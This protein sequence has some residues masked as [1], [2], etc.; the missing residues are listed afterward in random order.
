MVG[1]GP[2]SETSC[3]WGPAGPLLLEALDLEDGGTGPVAAAADH[4]AVVP[5]PAVRDGTA[6][7]AGVDVAGDGIPGIRAERDT[8]GA[9]PRCR[10]AWCRGGVSEALVH[11]ARPHERA[12]ARV[13]EVVALV[14]AVEDELVAHVE[15]RA[16]AAP[17]VGAVLLLELRVELLVQDRHPDRVMHGFLPLPVVGNRLVATGS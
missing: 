15:A 16:L 4:R 7:E 1:K 10:S 6:P 13:P 3:R 2:S 12:G 9:A 5:R 14:V 8:L 11:L 17:V